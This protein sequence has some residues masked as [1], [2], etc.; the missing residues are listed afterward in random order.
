MFLGTLSLRHCTKHQ[1]YEFY[2][3]MIVFSEIWSAFGQGSGTLPPSS[4]SFIQ[5]VYGISASGCGVPFKKCYTVLGQ[6]D[7]CPTWGLLGLLIIMLWKSIAAATALGDIAVV[8]WGAA[9]WAYRSWLT[10]LRQPNVS[11]TQ[12]YELCNW[13]QTNVWRWRDTS[14]L[15]SCCCQN[16]DPGG[17][18]P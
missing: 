15:G 14:A 12:T 6:E 9:S 5:L 18:L 17:P 1:G 13:K 7:S 11:L 2:V 3:T 4:P 10:H 8:T 16:T